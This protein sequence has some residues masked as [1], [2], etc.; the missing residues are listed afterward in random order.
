MSVQAEDIR[1]ALLGT[2]MD[3]GKSMLAVGWSVS[4]V[5]TR[6]RV[7]LLPLRGGLS[8]LLV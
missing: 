7:C 1:W 6:H 5:H 4:A 3:W 8:D 2:R